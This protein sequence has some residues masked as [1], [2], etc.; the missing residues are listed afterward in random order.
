MTCRKTDLVA[1]GG[2]TLSSCSYNLGLWQL[3]FQC[4]FN[5]CQRICCTSYSHGLI[6]IGTTGQRVTDGT[7][8]TCRCTTER[9]NFRRMVVCFILEHQ[10]P[11]LLFTIHINLDLDRTCVDFFR[12]IQIIEFS[13]LFENL[14]TDCT[15]I[16]QSD[17]LFLT[18]C[19]DDLSVFQ[20]VI[21]HFLYIFIF[22]ADV[23][24]NRIECCMTAVITPVC[25]NH[26]DF[27][28]SRITLFFIAEVSLQECDIRKI[29]RKTMISQE[30]FQSCFIQSSKAFQHF[31]KFRLLICFLNG[32]RLFKFCLTCFHRVDQCLSDF[33]LIFIR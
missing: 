26:L 21:I 7:T 23:F 8:K 2:I 28:N 31:R 20:I 29:H 4:I 10:Q 33:C 9:F 15:K 19:I 16:H 25:I 17:R 12:F 22:D 27:C 11:I 13:C 32:C 14:C 30:C 3:A 18:T 1:I 5:R 6:D 24:Q